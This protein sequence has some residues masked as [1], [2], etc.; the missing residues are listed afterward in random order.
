MRSA[1]P[2]TTRWAATRWAT[3]CRAAPAT[4][5]SRGWPATTRWMEGPGATPSMVASET[6]STSWAGSG[7]AG[8]GHPDPPAGEPD[9]GGFRHHRLTARVAPDF[10][11]GLIGDCG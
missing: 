8:A 11:F 2:A 10:V 5:G 1:A 7:D 4:T 3:G 9:H 6:I